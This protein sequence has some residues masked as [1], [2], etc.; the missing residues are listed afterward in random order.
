MEI[1]KRRLRDKRRRTTKRHT[2]SVK[3]WKIGLREHKQYEL[4]CKLN[5]RKRALTNL[6]NTLRDQQQVTRKIGV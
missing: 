4:N 1:T 3:L 2:K 6:L 5:A